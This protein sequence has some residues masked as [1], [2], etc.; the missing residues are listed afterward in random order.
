MM[1]Y[2]MMVMRGV[3]EEKTS[4]IAEVM[5]S[6]VKPFQMMIG[7]ITGIAAVGLTQFLMWIVLIIVLSSV[8]TAL[9]PHETLQQVQHAT[10]NMP[11]CRR[12]TKQRS[13]FKICRNK[14]YARRC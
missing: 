14:T 2:G 4:R 7:K 10:Q 6:S 13:N 3:M 9:L 1:I 12:C 8:A 11:N 5:V